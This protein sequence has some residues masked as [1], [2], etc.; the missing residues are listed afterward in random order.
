M[1]ISCDVPFR[2]FWIGFDI[3]IS[4]TSFCISSPPRTCVNSY[5]TFP[6][7]EFAK[8]RY[9]WEDFGGLKAM[10]FAWGRTEKHPC[11]I[12]NNTSLPNHCQFWLLTD[13]IHSNLVFS[14]RYFWCQ[15]RPN[16]QKDGHPLRF[17]FVMGSFE[18]AFIGQLDVL[19]DGFLNR[20]Q[21]S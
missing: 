17:E 11:K 2:N 19:N 13:G 20:E 14:P 15:E 6:S 21:L 4:K 9:W 5:P 7:C 12:E 8:W 18:F 1:K 3:V 16:T 10:P